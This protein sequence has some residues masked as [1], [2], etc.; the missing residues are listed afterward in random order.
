[1]ITSYTTLEYCEKRRGTES[2]W[3]VS[4]Y[5]STRWVYNISLK[6]GFECWIFWFIPIEH[7]KPRGEG[8]YFKVY[9]EERMKENNQHRGHGEHGNDK[10]N[11]N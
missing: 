6:M 8:R 11:D 5:Y 10:N 2:T 1:M 4:P 9:D 7:N 3:A